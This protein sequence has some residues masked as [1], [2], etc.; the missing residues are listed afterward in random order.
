VQL[1]IKKAIPSRITWESSDNIGKTYG[2]YMAYWM[3]THER[4]DTGVNMHDCGQWVKLMSQHMS[5]TLTENVN[6]VN[7]YTK[8]PT[9]KKNLTLPRM[10]W[11]HIPFT[12]E[13]FLTEMNEAVL[14]GDAE[15]LAKKKKK[16][17]SDAARQLQFSEDAW[18]HLAF[19]RDPVDRIVS[20]YFYRMKYD[21]QYPERIHSRTLLECIDSQ[22]SG[23]NAC[24]LPR[25]LMTR[26]FCGV[27]CAN[28][29]TLDDLDLKVALSNID[30]YFPFVGFMEEWNL[31]MLRLVYKFP[32]IFM[33]EEM[34][35]EDEKKGKYA[36]DGESERD[37]HMRS[38]ILKVMGKSDYNGHHVQHGTVTER[39]LERLGEI[40]GLDVQFY[41]RLKSRFLE[42]VA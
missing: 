40:N 30:R 15:P 33:T 24:F 14:R 5:N 13:P 11:A 38:D 37:K 18:A 16:V 41:H 23:D 20:S 39:D 9:A 4:Y 8:T 10:I 35:R 19:L 36:F 1:Q 2:P 3:E 28:K 21:K 42:C 31:S 7:T 27:H 6:L 29:H 12:G 25:N 34:M 32:S 22:I 17:A 26:W